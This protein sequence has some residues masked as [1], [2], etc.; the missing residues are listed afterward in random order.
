M[1]AIPAKRNP[2]ANTIESN[3]TPTR[4]PLLPTNYVIA[5]MTKQFISNLFSSHFTNM[6]A[7]ELYGTLRSS[8]RGDWRFEEQEA[9][10]NISKPK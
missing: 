6:I 7:Q 2:A 10:R 4:M 9:Q 5:Q 3:K 1:K 8:S